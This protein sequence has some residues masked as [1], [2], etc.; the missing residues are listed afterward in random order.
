MNEDDRHSH[1]FFF[2]A[3]FYYWEKQIVFRVG[4]SESVKTIKYIKWRQFFKFIGIKIALHILTNRNFV[5]INYLQY[6]VSINYLV[7]YDTI[8]KSWLKMVVS[9]F[10]RKISTK[11]LKILVPE[12]IPKLTHREIDCIYKHFGLR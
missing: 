9:N 2:D 12:N 7:L 11:S 8:R 6:A 10:D 4:L 1:G 3:T 5:L